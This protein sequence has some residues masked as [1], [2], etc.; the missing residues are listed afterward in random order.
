MTKQ[1]EILGPHPIT[2]PIIGAWLDFEDKESTE[3]QCLRTL[4][5]KKEIDEDVISR[6]SDCLL[7]YHHQDKAIQMM[8]TN[9]EKLGFPK[10][11]QY[12]EQARK[13][14]MNLNTQKGNAVEVLMTE[15]S[16]AAINKS[17]L[18]FAHRFRYNPNVDQSM[19]GDDM[20]IV[21][22]SDTAHPVI[23]LGEAKYRKTVKK[24]VVN[25]VLN[26]LSKGK[27]PLSLTFLRDCAETN[28]TEYAL[29]DDLLTKALSNY[30]IRYIGF[31]AGDTNA[32]KTVEKHW[33]SDNPRHLILVLSMNNPEKFVVDSFKKATEKLTSKE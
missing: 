1:E 18:T 14:P 11:A 6:F 26:S 20:L 28:E 31:I 13:M 16:L 8:K 10:F 9:L 19:K 29:L 24:E 30:D 25:D 5:E 15:Y 2:H 27:M 17:D 12:Y 4:S 3:T 22:F 7:N 23:Y 33:I 21:D 32:Y